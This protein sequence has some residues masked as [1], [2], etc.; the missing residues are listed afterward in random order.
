M[1]L[2]PKSRLTLIMLILII[3]L[4]IFIARRASFYVIFILITGIITYYSKLYHIP[5]DVS[6]LFFFQVV[7][8][9]YYGIGFTLLFVFLGYIIPKLLAGSGM[10]W[11]SYAFVISSLTVSYLSS[12]IAL[13][14]HLVGYLASILQYAGGIFISMVSK[15]FFLSA[16]DGIANT[17]NNLLWFL[18]FSDLV[19]F[20][21]R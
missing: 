1:K 12:F 8:T 11:E 2:N 15:P 21:L 13:P 14:L 7:I 3:L 18:I 16:A 19:V 4:L 17:V 5:I 20:L 9:R 10:K 6:P